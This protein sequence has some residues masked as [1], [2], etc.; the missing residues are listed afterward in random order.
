MCGC[1]VGGEACCLLRAPT[2]DTGAD[3]STRISIDGLLAWLPSMH[4]TWQVGRQ[5]AEQALLFTPPPGCV[6]VLPGLLAERPAHS[7]VLA[8]REVPSEEVAV[9]RKVS[10]AP[11]KSEMNVLD[12]GWL[13]LRPLCHKLLLGFPCCS[14]LLPA[15]LHAPMPL[16]ACRSAARCPCRL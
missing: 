4:A 3:P 7:V 13:G 12:C 2:N 6:Q 15:C 11:G 5:A 16:P 1:V 9:E 14:L 8:Q 10:G